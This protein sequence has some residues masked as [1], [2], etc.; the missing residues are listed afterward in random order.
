MNDFEIKRESKRE[1]EG[2]ITNIVSSESSFTYKV[3]GGILVGTMWSFLS[4]IIRDGKSSERE[5]H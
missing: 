3:F 2:E 5:I 4:T 1:V